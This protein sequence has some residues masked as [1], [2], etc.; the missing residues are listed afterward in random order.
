MDSFINISPHPLTAQAHKQPP[1]ATFF[2]FPLPP[3]L[4]LGEG[5]WLERCLN[6]T[7][8]GSIYQQGTKASALKVKDAAD[9][10]NCEQLLEV[11]DARD[12]FRSS[13]PPYPS[14]PLPLHLFPFP[15][16][17]QKMTCLQC[18]RRLNSFFLQ[19]TQKWTS[20]LAPTPHLSSSC[21]LTFSLSLS[22]SLP[23][24]LPPS[25]SFLSSYCPSVCLSVCPTSSSHC[26]LSYI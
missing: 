15:S 11:C 22:L 23:P 1:P 13:L 4:T 19:T 24:S 8:Y 2:P 9:E 20:F 21:P 3:S 18:G 12:I 16:L 6:G 17:L 14:L 26:F 10:E 7:S 5:A 25:D